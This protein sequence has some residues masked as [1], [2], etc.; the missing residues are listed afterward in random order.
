[1]YP[2]MNQLL[3][4]VYDTRA[5]GYF[6][7]N[8][9][10]PAKKQTETLYEIEN[11]VANAMKKTLP[12][13]AYTFISDNVDLRNYQ[14]ILFTTDRKAYVDNL[15]I[16]NLRVIVNSKKINNIRYI[17]KHLRHVNCLL[18]DAGFYIGRFNDLWERKR[19]IYKT[20]GPK[21][22]RL[23]WFLDFIL[24]RFLPKIKYIGKIYFWLTRGKFHV[25]SRSEVLG[26]MIYCGFEVIDTKTIDGITYFIALKTKPPS[27][28][29]TPTYHPLITLQRIGKDGKM[30]GVYKMR[31]MFPYSEYLQDYVVKMNGYNE[32]GKPARDFRLTGWGK[33]FRKLW[34]DELP[35]IINFIKGDLALVGVRPLSKARFKELPEEVQEARIKFKPGLIPPYVALNM[36]D[37]FG[38]IEAERIYMAEKVMHP[39]RT[40]MKF[41][42][43]AVFNVLTGKI[44][45]A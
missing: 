18:P 34:L 20:I 19:N 10:K 12:Q 26:R 9:T 13:E 16:D 35:Q 6:L 1:M 23:I 43:M 3:S 33:I 17:N 31:T 32:Y 41:F 8:K 39:F 29:K 27:K 45:S 28:H 44:R 22:G 40:D 37:S 24:N 42:F 38:N 4:T 14:N 36:P 7:F 2:T 30:I 21:L 25:V 15:D 11:N 5:S